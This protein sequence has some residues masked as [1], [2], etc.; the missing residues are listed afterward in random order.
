M[1]KYKIVM[2]LLC[3]AFVGG[4]AQDDASDAI[5]AIKTA[6]DTLTGGGLSD[7][8][9]ATAKGALT[10]GLG[11]AQTALSKENAKNSPDQKKIMRLLT[12]IQQ[13]NI[14]FVAGEGSDDSSDQDG[15]N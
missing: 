3:V 8:A 4:N 14:A 1:K 12:V 11:L 9:I 13:G 10:I 7:D 6:L 2:L 15:T 5:A